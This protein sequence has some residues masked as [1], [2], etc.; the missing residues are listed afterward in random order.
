MKRDMEL[1]RLILL[2]IEKQPS[3]SSSI[4]LEF[5]GYSSEQINYHTMLLHEAG[6]IVAID[7]SSLSD[8]CWMPQRLTWQGHEF[9]EASR[10][11]IA[12]NKTKEIMAR[13]G[14]FVFEIA[15]SILIKLVEQQL[16]GYIG[17]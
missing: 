13:G 16:F 17:H 4:E 9:L 1:A 3:Y 5:D 8:L 15:K 6:L 12:W 11:D 10:N 7:A 2:E 14:G